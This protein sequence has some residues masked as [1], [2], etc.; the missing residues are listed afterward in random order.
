MHASQASP[1][2][3]SPQ[4]PRRLTA[5]EAASYRA[6]GY[7]QVDG[8]FAPTEI[9]RFAAAVH[10]H[11]AAE[12]QR[13]AA[14]PPDPG[15]QR[16]PEER[17]NHL[18]QLGACFPPIQ[19]LAADPRILAL[20]ADLVGPGIRLF[21]GKVISKG[22]R[23][24]EHHCHWHQDDA[25]WWHISPSQTR[26]SVWVPLIDTGPHNGG[27]RV[28]PGPFRQDLRSHEARS[29][30]RRGSCRLSFAPGTEVLDGERT[31]QVAAGG[32]VLFSA[33]A[34]HASGPNPT[35]EHRRACILTYQEDGCTGVDGDQ[36]LLT[37]P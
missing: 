16:T 25:Y 24:L 26:L 3:A 7:V 34:P 20:I 1:A 9:A 8:V 15:D 12:R 37:P 6:Q 19:S 23:E 32:L 4:C 30:R 21:S 10:A 28:L 36:P 11:H 5:A 17:D 31:L 2:Q 18:H 33:R 27:L 14:R 22:P 35:A 29:S 13:A